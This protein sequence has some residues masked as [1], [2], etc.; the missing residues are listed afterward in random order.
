M[1]FSG[2]AQMP[3]SDFSAPAPSGF[4]NSPTANHS[5]LETV[6]TREKRSLVAGLRRGWRSLVV[7]APG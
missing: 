5:L 4:S 1:D 2:R 3:C 6:R 7:Q